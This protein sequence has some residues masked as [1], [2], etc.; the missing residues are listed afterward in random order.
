MTDGRAILRWASLHDFARVLNELE[1]RLP[2][3]ER[4]RAAR[5][6]VG[7]A[8][9]RF[10]LARTMLRR[11]LGEMLRTDPKTLNFGVSERG[12]PY[13][14]RPETP[15]PPKFNLSHS[16]GVVA[17]VVAH[18]E[19][20][21]DVEGLRHITRAAQLARRFFSAGERAVVLAADGAARD[22]AFL[23]IWTQKEAY[24]KATGLGVGMPLNEVETEPDPT[25]PR[26]ILAV[27]GD[28]DEGNRWELLQVEVP[29]A[30]C[31]VAMRRPALDLEVRRVTPA[32][33]DL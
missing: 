16:R 1:L 29:D 3:D 17:V 10:V 22:R 12:K 24:L 9:Q 6:R 30:V 13:L 32:D 19:I 2:A 21:I 25:A 28:R 8:R 7:E 4:R 23:R 31:V 27:A 14:V 20:G 26:R 18:T 5:F 33:L 11:E 15:E